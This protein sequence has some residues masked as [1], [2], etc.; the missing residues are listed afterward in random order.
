[1]GC[2]SNQSTLVKNTKLTIDQEDNGEQYQW[3]FSIATLMNP[4][5]LNNIGIFP[6]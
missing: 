5:V 2:A 6:N 3:Y 4:I 1:M